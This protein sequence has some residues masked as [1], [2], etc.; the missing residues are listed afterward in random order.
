MTRMPDP[1]APRCD[2]GWL[3]NAAAEPSFP[4]VFDDATGEYQ[5]VLSSEFGGRAPIYHC[6]FCGGSAPESKRDEL[7]EHISSDEM[8]RL[9]QLTDGVRNVADAIAKLGQPEEDLANGHSETPRAK[10]GEA[11]RTQWFRTLRYSNLSKTAI[12]DAVVRVDDRVHFVFMPK[13]KAA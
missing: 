12:V 11:P 7:F 5:I 9:N 1:S 4:V 13:P 10:E 2:C 3:E 6:P 8:H